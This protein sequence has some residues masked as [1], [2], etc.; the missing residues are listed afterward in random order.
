MT[1]YLFPVPVHIAGVAP[2]GPPDGAVL[3][4][5]RGDALGGQDDRARRARD[6]VEERADVVRPQ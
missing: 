4:V 5:E 3:A 1:I 2:V 6:D